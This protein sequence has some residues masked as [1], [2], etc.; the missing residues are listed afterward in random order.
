[1][2]SKKPAAK[3]KNAVLEVNHSQDDG[4][5]YVKPTKKTKVASS[6]TDFFDTFP[7][8]GS[9]KPRPRIKKPA[10]KTS[11]SKARSDEE[12]SFMLS[13]SPPKAIRRPARAA[14]SKKKIMSSEPDDYEDSS[15][16][17]LD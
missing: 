9:S 11:K 16:Q 10:T 2:A 14:A 4:E 13:D 7:S 3:R 12:D 5:V 17:V 6:I 15:F 8:E 1:M